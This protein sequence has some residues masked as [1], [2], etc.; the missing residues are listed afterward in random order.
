MLHSPLVISGSLVARIGVAVMILGLALELGAAT[1][2]PRSA[3][4]LRR[5]VP[6]QVLV[7][8][9]IGAV[10]MILGNAMIRLALAP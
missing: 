9:A 1:L 10:V 2:L 6:R 3:S 7:A 8:L 5:G 4:E